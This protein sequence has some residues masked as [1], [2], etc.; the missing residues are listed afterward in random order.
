MMYVFRFLDDKITHLLTGS[1]KI[2]SATGGDLTLNP[3]S[4]RTFPRTSP[5]LKNTNVSISSSFPRRVFI[6]LFYEAYL[7]VYFMGMNKLV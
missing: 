2:Q 1:L 6:L 3:L 4:T 7:F 5:N